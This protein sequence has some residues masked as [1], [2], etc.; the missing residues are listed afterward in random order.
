MPILS[1]CSLIEGTHPFF[2]GLAWGQVLLLVSTKQNPA[3][4]Y[5]PR[6]LPMFSKQFFFRKLGNVCFSFYL[7]SCESF[8][9]L[10]INQWRDTLARY[11]EGLLQ[12]S[13]LGAV[14]GVG[15]LL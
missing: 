5:C 3:V 12:S 1:H 9:N 2:I 11:P 7:L 4:L 14:G 10:P 15:S 6:D 8:L 13:T